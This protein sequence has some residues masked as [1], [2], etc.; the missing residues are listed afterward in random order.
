MY[1]FNNYLF[2]CSSGLPECV[3]NDGTLYTTSINNIFIYI[4]YVM[5]YS[6]GKQ[7]GNNYIL[8]LDL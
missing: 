6:K 3:F 7:S 8:I 5:Q 4:T 2:T 1:K